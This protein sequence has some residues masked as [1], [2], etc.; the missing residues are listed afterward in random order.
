MSRYSWMWKT[1]SIL[2]YPNIKNCAVKYIL[3]FVTIYI[4]IIIFYNRD[5]QVEIPQN[6]TLINATK[7][8]EDHKNKRHEKET[9]QINLSWWL[10]ILPICYI[11]FKVWILHEIECNISKTINFKHK[12]VCLKRCVTTK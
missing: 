6:C 4:W 7:L 12:P 9:T 1:C 10:L 11:G 8:Q 5:H 3:I 2:K